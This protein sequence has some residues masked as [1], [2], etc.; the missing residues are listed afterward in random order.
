MY[1]YGANSPYDYINKL[2]DF[3]ITNIADR[4]DQDILILHGMDDHFIHWKLYKDEIDRLINARSITL[5]LFT[6]KE[7]ASNH[8]QC[9]NT[10]LVLDT[11]MN[12]LM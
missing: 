5:R 4:I 11:I 12:W 8:C 9:G 2:N 7:E 3:Q 10:K 1:A 6:D